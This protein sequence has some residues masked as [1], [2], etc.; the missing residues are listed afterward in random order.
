MMGEGKNRDQ[1]DLMNVKD[2]EGAVPTKM[3]GV[4]KQD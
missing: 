4:I 2:I 1:R 3:V